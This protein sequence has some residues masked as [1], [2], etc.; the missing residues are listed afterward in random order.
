MPSFNKHTTIALFLIIP[1]LLVTL[2]FFILPAFSAILQSLFYS[3]AFGIQQSFA[4]LY[5]FIDLW[6]STEY[7]LAL[8]NT[9][10]IAISVTLL[11]M[12]LG[13]SLA[14]LVHGR[15]HGQQIYKSLLLWPYAVAPAVAAILWRFLCHPTLGWMTTLLSSVRMLS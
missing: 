2:V 12:I 10:I 9:L 5:N 14:L 4:G 7:L 1:Q 6:G 13:L 3:D 11:T 15:K 8:W